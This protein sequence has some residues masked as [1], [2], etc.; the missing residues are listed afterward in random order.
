[1]INL[2][3]SYVPIDSYADSLPLLLNEFLANKAYKDSNFHYQVINFY[4]NLK[5]N[6]SI[7]IMKVFNS[8]ISYINLVT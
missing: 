5:K 4:E 8:F 6:S 3:F 7:N 1:M 2:I